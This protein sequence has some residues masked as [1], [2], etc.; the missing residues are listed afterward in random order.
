MKCPKWDGVP[1]LGS[2]IELYRAC[3]SSTATS[4][5]KHLDAG[6]A[7]MQRWRGG[8]DVGS[9]GFL[10]ASQPTTS[11]RCPSA[12]LAEL[13]ENVRELLMSGEPAN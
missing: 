12:Y 10:E 3:I 4:E 2:T 1:L 6:P 13:G 7:K 9:G 8:D 5:I 11:G